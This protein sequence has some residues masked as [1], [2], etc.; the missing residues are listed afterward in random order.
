MLCCV[1]RLVKWCYHCYVGLQ[2]KEVK[3]RP[4]NQRAH[5]KEG[6]KAASGGVSS[7]RGRN[8]DHFRQHH[9]FNRVASAGSGGDNSNYS[10][11]GGGGG[12]APEA[13]ILS[14]NRF[15]KLE[16]DPELEGSSISP[17]SST[18]GDYLSKSLSTSSISPSSSASFTSRGTEDRRM[19][20]ERGGGGGGNGR[21]RGGGGGRRGSFRGKGSAKDLTESASIS[22]GSSKEKW[23]SEEGQNKKRSPKQIKF[24]LPGG[25]AAAEACGGISGSKELSEPVQ[26]V[27]E[28]ATGIASASSSISSV[29]SSEWVKVGNDVD[30]TGDGS[31]EGSTSPPQPKSSSVEAAE[32]GRLVYN[33]VRISPTLF[34]KHDSFGLLL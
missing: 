29:S 26:G 34:H 16:I 9:R 27:S 12:R 13:R 7:S 17:S 18:S 3:S 20:R 4:F 31:E 21:E 6:S 24:D 10:S 22:S 30:F 5:T 25:S 33:R 32:N 19:G 2:D 8:S 14:S 1:N 11:A 15:E 23:R 28:Q